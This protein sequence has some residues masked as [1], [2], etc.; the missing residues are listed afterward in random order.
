VGSVRVRKDNGSLFIDF[1]IDGN[2]YREQTALLDNTANRKRLEKLL[3]KIEVDITNGTFEY[4]EYFPQSRNLQKFKRSELASAVSNSVS[5]KESASDR[6]TTPLFKEFAE[7]WFAEKEIEWRRSHKEGVR[8]DITKL[9]VPQFGAKEVGNIT[10]AEILAF[11]AQLAKVPARGKKTPLS[12]SRINKILNPLRQILCEAADRYDFRTPFH[13]IKQLRV[14]KSDVDPF[15]IEEVK[16]II[17]T[18]REDFRNYLAV[19]FFTGMRT[20]EVDGLQ[21]RYVDFDRRLILIRETFVRGEDEYTKT[22]ASQRDIQMNQAVYDALKHQELSTR[23]HSKYVFCN[24][25]GLPL[26]YK[27]VNNR[28]WKPLLRHLGLKAR[29]AYQCRHTAATLWLASGESPEWIARQLGHSN[30]EMLFRVYSRYVPNLTRQDGS[31]FERLLLQSGAIE[32][33]SATSDIKITR[34][35][36]E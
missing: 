8:D 32:P 22:D 11:R 1:R 23:E 6:G 33:Q 24:R 28:V 21:W 30:T 31:A 27:N 9:L 35:E 4:Q 26:D 7:V 13:N 25:M 3:A 5:G 18:V 19:R 20:G 29:R 16:S 2:R 10:K 14:K 34:P 12:S 17:A 36:T 15:T